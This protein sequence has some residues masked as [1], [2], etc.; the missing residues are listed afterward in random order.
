M[1]KLK[2]RYLVYQLMSTLDWMGRSD[3]WF[4]RSELITRTMGII[5]NLCM[6]SDT[7][8]GMDDKYLITDFNK[9]REYRNK[10]NDCIDQEDRKKREDMIF[11]F[12][13]W[14][15]DIKVLNEDE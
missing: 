4:K 15:H 8:F 13:V 11:E 3:D 10:L 5:R 14:L 6:D 7:Y 1:D 9:A 12:Y 2:R